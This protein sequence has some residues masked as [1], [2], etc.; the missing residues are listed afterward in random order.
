MCIRDRVITPSYTARTRTLTGVTNLIDDA[1]RIEVVCS[2]DPLLRPNDIA[3][4]GTISF[5]VGSIR[6]RIEP[7][8]ASMTVLER[9]DG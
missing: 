2:V 9:A 4:A 5:L 1:G 8:T 6:Y 7:E 3:I